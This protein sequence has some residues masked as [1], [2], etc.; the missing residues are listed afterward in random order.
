MIVI[1]NGL[2]YLLHIFRLFISF[3]VILETSYK[4]LIAQ[5]NF[6]KKKILFFDI[7]IEKTISSQLM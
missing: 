4:M 2:I 5:K 1:S 7:K 6:E 3:S